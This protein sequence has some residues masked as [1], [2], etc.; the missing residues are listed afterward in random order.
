MTIGIS[1]FWKLFVLEYFKFKFDLIW[2]NEIVKPFGG[3]CVVLN[4]SLFLI[5]SRHQHKSLPKMMTS[6]NRPR[7]LNHFKGHSDAVVDLAFHPTEN[8]LASASADKSVHLW[9]F[10]S[11]VRCY[12]LLG[13]THAVNSV[14]WSPT[15]EVMGSGSDDRT[16]RLWIPTIRGASGEL[17][18]HLGAVFS[19]DFN[20]TGRK[21]SWVYGIRWNA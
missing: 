20:P 15:G 1:S 2:L 7:L 21:V 8:R 9:T 18:G 13:H 19:V 11:N 16:A 10:G 14:A 6:S 17:K 3:L 5:L 12:K 4:N